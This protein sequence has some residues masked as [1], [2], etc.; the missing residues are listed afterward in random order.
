L[1]RSIMGCDRMA[2]SLA[3]DASYFLAFLS[4]RA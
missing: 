1:S 4:A 2:Q 3:C